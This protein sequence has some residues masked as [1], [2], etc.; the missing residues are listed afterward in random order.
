MTKAILMALMR[1]RKPQRTCQLHA[2]R[3]QAVREARP[4]LRVLCRDFLEPGDAFNEALHVPREMP[5][6]LRG[7]RVDVA[8]HRP[9]AAGHAAEPTQL[10]RSEEHTSELQSLRHL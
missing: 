4:P 9:Y 3:A 8:T 5:D 6:V 10:L 1:N 2:P 7:P